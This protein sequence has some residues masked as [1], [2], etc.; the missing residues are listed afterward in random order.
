MAHDEGVPDPTAPLDLPGAT[1]P[2]AGEVAPGPAESTGAAAASESASDD[3][4]GL[5]AVIDRLEGFL[6]RSALSELEVEAG[7][8][9]FVLRTAAAIDLGA[10]PTATV[11]QP[12]PAEPASTA[13]HEGTAEDAGPERHAILAPLTGLFYASPAPGAAAYVRVGTEVN[14]GQVI[15]LIEAMKLFNEIRSTAG[16]KVKRIFA[17]NGQLVRAHQPLLELEPI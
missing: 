1:G 4:A 3:V 12:G 13:A 7:G 2:S 11:E 5:L 15:G 14:V 9:V 10:L 8:T 17:E 16:G 6:E